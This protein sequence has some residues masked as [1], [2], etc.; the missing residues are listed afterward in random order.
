MSRPP[1]WQFVVAA[2]TFMRIQIA[3]V[4]ALV[5]AMRSWKK[6]RQEKEQIQ[7]L[8]FTLTVNGDVDDDVGR[9][10]SRLF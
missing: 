1:P 4:M 5:V 7:F 10:I 9:H 6:I 8:L 2:T 3:L